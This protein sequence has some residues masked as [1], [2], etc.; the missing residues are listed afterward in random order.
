MVGVLMERVRKHRIEDPLACSSP[1]IPIRS[2]CCLSKLL[3]AKWMWQ[4]C[5]DTWWRL[6]VLPE[7]NFY[8]NNT[9]MKLCCT[10]SVQLSYMHKSVFG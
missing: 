1:G 4:H 9:R 2:Q 5:A 10:L 6:G 7:G 3:L 8:G